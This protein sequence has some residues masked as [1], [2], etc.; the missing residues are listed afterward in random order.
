M[1][2]VGRAQNGDEFS[3]SHLD[4]VVVRGGHEP[5]AVTGAV[6]PSISLSTSRYS[7]LF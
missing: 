6:T 3:A 2:S 5:D 4:T 1:G 7:T